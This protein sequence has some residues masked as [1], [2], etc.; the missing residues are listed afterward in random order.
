MPFLT[1]CVW[2]ITGINIS[3]KE[4]D[5]AP[6]SFPFL[7][8]P[9]PSFYIQSNFWLEWEEWPLGLSAALLV[10]HRHG[11]SIVLSCGTSRME[12]AEEW[13]G[14]MVRG[15]CRVLLSSQHLHCPV[16]LHLY[17]VKDKLVRIS[18][19]QWQSIKPSASPF[20]EIHISSPRPLL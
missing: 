17:E 11:S 12:N 8:T 5:R 18:R 16:R 20:T 3:K 14:T 1:P 7:R 2:L 4:Y 15:P 9:P 6:W 19:Q 10:S 13:C